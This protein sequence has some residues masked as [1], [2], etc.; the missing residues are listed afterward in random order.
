MNWMEQHGAGGR[1]RAGRPGYA[2]SCSSRP[3]AQ[4]RMPDPRKR[5]LR[6]AVSTRR[7]EAAPGLGG[8][9]S[10]HWLR[11]GSGE[12]GPCAESRQEC[13]GCCGSPPHP[14]GP[15]PLSYGNEGPGRERPPRLPRRPPSPPPH[16]PRR[17]GSWRG[18]AFSAEQTKPAAAMG[19]DRSPRCVGTRKSCRAGMG[20]QRR[21]GSLIP[22][23]QAAA[24]HAPPG[25]Q[26]RRSLRRRLGGELVL[27]LVCREGAGGC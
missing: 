24:L 9:S 20:P 25:P 6:P 12:R 13:E 21:T 27:V 7:S 17:S 19:P 16:P 22:E 11:R 8:T 14:G 3:Q 15:G 4:G 23:E 18:D 2:G 1:G 10:S 26:F 5:G